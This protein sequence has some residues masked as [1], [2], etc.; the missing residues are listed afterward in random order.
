MGR[1]A[2]LQQEF[3]RAVG[4]DLLLQY[5]SQQQE[6][7]K[8]AGV[9]AGDLS[10]EVHVLDGRVIRVTCPA[11]ASVLTLKGLIQKQIAVDPFK[12]QLFHDSK[13]I[14]VCG[15]TWLSVPLME[16]MQLVSHAMNQAD[17]VLY[18]R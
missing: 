11:N 2:E 15:V 1:A 7:K 8:D 14:K 5:Q 13:E 3:Q 17:A 16:L 10:I 6:E 9:V 18:S 12:L 4:I